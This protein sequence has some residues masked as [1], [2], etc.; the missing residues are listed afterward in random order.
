[1]RKKKQ[2][3]LVKVKLINNEIKIPYKPLFA[4]SFKYEILNNLET[5]LDNI[6]INL[7]GKLYYLPSIFCNHT[8]FD[9]VENRSSIIAI[10]IND[11]LLLIPGYYIMYYYDKFP[12][13]NLQ[14]K[15]INGVRI[16]N[17]IDIINDF[18][19]YLFFKIFQY[20]TDYNSENIENIDDILLFIICL[21][22]SENRNLSLIQE[23]LL[24]K[25]VDLEFIE[26]FKDNNFV[27]END[28]YKYTKMYLDDIYNKILS[29]I[30]YTDIDMYLVE[31][32]CDN[33]DIYTDLKKKQ[34]VSTTIKSVITGGSTDIYYKKYIKYKTKYL[35]L[36]ENYK[37]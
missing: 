31:S 14:L 25:N 35:K 15:Q 13:F 29:K 26:K 28:M 10:Y 3:Q 24:K 34:N 16:S 9:Y 20:D 6:A 32:T 8:A 18:K 5:H 33:Y 17:K 2:M 22:I 21:Q 37:I 23:I 7:I 27:Y 11:K 30:N 12:I 4:L 1:M 36:L 19:Q